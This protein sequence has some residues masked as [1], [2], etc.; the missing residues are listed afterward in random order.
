MGSTPGNSQ[1]PLD[2]IQPYA[3]NV[4]TRPTDPI[5]GPTPASVERSGSQIAIRAN[6]PV[7]HHY[8]T[9]RQGDCGALL[10]AQIF[11]GKTTYLSASMRKNGGG[12]IDAWDNSIA[13]LLPLIP[14]GDIYLVSDRGA[15]VYP[16]LRTPDT[17]DF[18]F[19]RPRRKYYLDV[20]LVDGTLCQT[21]VDLSKVGTHATLSWTIAALNR[22]FDASPPSGM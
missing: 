21:T 10:A 8:L 12:A 9:L 3:S 7:G 22:C 4:T 15:T 6:V 18:E 1:L 19:V 20:R 5:D 16:A 2:R 17:Y 13:G 14:Y 11:A